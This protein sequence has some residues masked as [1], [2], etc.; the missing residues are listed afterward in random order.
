MATVSSQKQLKDEWACF[1]QLISS[2]STA[3]IIQSIIEQN[4]A[5]TEEK[6]KVETAYKRNFAE[7]SAALESHKDERQAHEKTIRELGLVKKDNATSESLLGAAKQVLEQKVSEIAKLQDG[8]SEM[9]TTVDKLK[10]SVRK[11]E[12]LGAKYK[13]V[14]QADLNQV[15]AI[16][17]ALDLVTTEM[18][19]AQAKLNTLANFSVSLHPFNPEAV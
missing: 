6:R 19:S 18:K 16:Q 1:Q 14:H 15:Q 12:D 8:M 3:N 10:A 7:C 17:T 2:H 5:L 9:Q 13:T 11:H 4:D